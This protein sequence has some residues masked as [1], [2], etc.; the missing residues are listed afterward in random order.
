MLPA[1]P[2]K[3]LHRHRRP[4]SHVYPDRT[5]GCLV[6]WFTD[7]EKCEY[8]KKLADVTREEYEDRLGFLEPV[9][10]T[11]LATSPSPISIKPAIAR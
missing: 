5:L 2:A 10:D 9:Y 11:P 4:T 1:P 8:F 3:V 7:A 6:A